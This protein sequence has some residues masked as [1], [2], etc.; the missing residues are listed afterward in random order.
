MGN[1]LTD[2]FRSINAEVVII[3]G[4]EPRYRTTLG[5][6]NLASVFCTALHDAPEW[7]V[8]LAADHKNLGTLGQGWSDHAA[9]RKNGTR[10]CGQ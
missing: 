8:G 4:A 6:H 7:I 2:Q 3:L 1:R 5:F 10:D 9:Q